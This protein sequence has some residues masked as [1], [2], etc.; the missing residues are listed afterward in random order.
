[1]LSKKK[2]DIKKERL[3]S[4]LKRI[5][6]DALKFSKKNSAVRAMLP[7]NIDEIV[8]QAKK[9]TRDLSMSLNISHVSRISQFI[10][11]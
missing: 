6:A 8:A 10:G 2:I 4:Q 11:S 7:D 5:I 3:K 1:M 9:E